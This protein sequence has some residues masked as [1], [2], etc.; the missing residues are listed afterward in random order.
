MFR[1]ACGA[2]VLS[3]QVASSGLPLR[4]STRPSRP[5]RRGPEVGA[6]PPGAAWV[7]EWPE[8]SK[9]RHVPGPRPRALLVRSRRDTLGP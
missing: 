8:P 5:W 7:V 6:A 4:R 2:E 3:G 9:R 1:L